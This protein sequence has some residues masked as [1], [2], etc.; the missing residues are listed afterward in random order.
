VIVC[1][2]RLEAK[3]IVSAPAA[4]LA[5]TSASRSDKFPA[6][7]KSASVALGSVESSSSARVVTM[8][9]A[10]RALSACAAPT[11]KRQ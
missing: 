11:D 6:P 10:I 4:A 2:A 8:K 3:V 1:P 5:R 7:P 9:S